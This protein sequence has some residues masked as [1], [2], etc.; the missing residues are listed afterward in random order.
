V[1]ARSATRRSAAPIVIIKQVQS[2]EVLNHAQE[3]KGVETRIRC[4]LR[5]HGRAAPPNRRADFHDGSCDGQCNDTSPACLLPRAARATLAYDIQ[6]AV[7]ASTITTGAAVT[8]IC[9]DLGGRGNLAGSKCWSAVRKRA[10]RFLYSVERIKKGARGL[11]GCQTGDKR[12][13]AG[14]FGRLE[15]WSARE[16]GQ[17]LTGGEGKLRASACE[18]GGHYRHRFI[19]A[20]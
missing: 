2:K 12:Q 3:V 7:S 8:F 19:P 1:A 20:L 16:N 11:K 5:H 14:S 10:A 4:C 15:I 9:F 13:S 17:A 18:D 6:A